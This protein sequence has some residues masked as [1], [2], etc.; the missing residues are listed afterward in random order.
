MEFQ[1]DN[2]LKQ[3]ELQQAILLYGTNKN[4]TLDATFASYHSVKDFGTPDAPNVQILPGEPLSQESLLKTLGK[5]TDRYAISTDILPESVLSYS[6]MHMIWWIPKGRRRVFLKTPAD[7]HQSEVT[8]HP[9]MVF[10]VLRSQWYV[11]AL[12]E[13][14]RPGKETKLYRAPFLNIFD[15]GTVCRGSA[16]APEAIGVSE[17]DRWES[18]FFD[19]LFTHVN[20]QR[21][22]NYK[23][24][25][26]G[27]WRDLM[28]GKHKTFPTKALMETGTT[29]GS[30]MNQA[31]NFTGRDHG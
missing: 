1:V 28:A 5:L 16:K 29:L 8:P 27:L 21:K 12:K 22:V 10:I 4:G 26:Y 14:R 31:L 30:F 17:I 20:G 11:F 23:G 19:S 24:G 18:A 25:E 7:G 9:A 15:N 2:G 13:S 6:P 3:I